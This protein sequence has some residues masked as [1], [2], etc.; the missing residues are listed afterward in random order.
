MHNYIILY[1]FM[2]TLIY[3][4][5]KIIKYCW[6]CLLGI[7]PKV[8]IESLESYSQPTSAFQ[9][10]GL[11]DPNAAKRSVKSKIDTLRYESGEK[12]GGGIFDIP[13]VAA[14]RQRTG[15]QIV[16][17]KINRHLIYSHARTPASCA[18][19]RPEWIYTYTEVHAM[20]IAISILELYFF[21][22]TLCSEVL[23]L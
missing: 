23:K 10:R 18:P 16:W 11:L 6:Q 2:Q 1:S 12:Y 3:F 21:L 4:T 7:S 14:E 17:L 8:C 19:K 20:Y 9:Y 22:A 15:K 13:I 5:R